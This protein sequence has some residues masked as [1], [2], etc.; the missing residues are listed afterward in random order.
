MTP[1]KLC[2]NLRHRVV[3]HNER[4]F[5]RESDT[6]TSLCRKLS[7]R[8]VDYCNS[9]P[10]VCT[11]KCHGSPEFILENPVNVDGTTLALRVRVD[12]VRSSSC[13]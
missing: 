1:V 4:I 13:S 6:V 5:C 8:G 11:V 7:C 3:F 2:G 9:R 10:L 12:L